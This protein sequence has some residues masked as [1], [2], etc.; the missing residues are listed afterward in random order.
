MR[1]VNRGWANARHGWLLLVVL[2]GMTANLSAVLAAP[3]VALGYT[4]KYPPGFHHFEYVDPHASR[5]GDLIL[6]AFG[7]FDSF[8]P[9]QLK[10]IP[11]AGLSELVFESLMEQSLD[12]P[13]SLYAHLA[14]DIEI[15]DCPQRSAD[16]PLNL[17]R[18]AANPSLDGLAL[19]ARVR[20]AGQHRVLGRDPTAGGAP[21]ES[22]LPVFDAH[23]AEHDRLA[24]S[25][26]RRTLGMLEEADADVEGPEHVRAA[27]VDTQHA[28]PRFR[29]DYN[30]RPRGRLCIR[31]RS[32][33]PNIRARCR[34]T[35]W[36]S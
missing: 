9:F 25:D 17:V 15:G 10:G 19:G 31:R 21:E 2:V 29:A 5:G 8:N 14:E 16:E 36:D 22:R 32:A 26:E 30:N 4:P 1:R 33:W 3:S 12:E 34:N 35:R 18:A 24:H 13:Y 20:R 27:A 11:A 28:K 6:S 7:N 23:G